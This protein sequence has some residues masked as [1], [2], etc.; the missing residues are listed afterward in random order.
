MAKTEQEKKIQE[1]K[2]IEKKVNF[3]IETK[4]DKY[5]QINWK[6]FFAL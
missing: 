3:E 2:K 5:L 6:L 4:K 1:L